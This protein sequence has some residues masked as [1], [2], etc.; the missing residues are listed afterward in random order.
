MEAKEAQRDLSCPD[1]PSTSDVRPRGTSLHDVGFSA[2][3]LSQS[4]PGVNDEVQLCRRELLEA[5][6]RHE[7]ALKVWAEER[8]CWERERAEWA[9][10]KSAID[11]LQGQFHTLKCMQLESSDARFRELNERNTTQ[12]QALTKYK[13]LVDTLRAKIGTQAETIKTLRQSERSTLSHSL[14]TRARL[15]DLLSSVR[16]A[17]SVQ[18]SRPPL[19]FTESF[20]TSRATIVGASASSRTNTLAGIAAP[21]S[22][23]KLDS[24]YGTPK[25]LPSTSL[26][27]DGGLGFSPEPPAA[28]ESITALHD[29]IISALAGWAQDRLALSAEQSQREEL[30]QN[31]GVENVGILFSF[32]SRQLLRIL[33]VLLLLFILYF[34]IL[35]RAT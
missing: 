30:E 32:F 27:G 29:L 5:C 15:A 28:A 1:S 8:S 21:S 33:P 10:E 9:S 24:A 23:S 34:C 2:Q 6:S 11:I 19:A 12:Q 16:A 7:Q 26:E 4:L 3:K 17:H 18:M 14:L 22:D 31:V 25:F 13:S 20:S 35:K